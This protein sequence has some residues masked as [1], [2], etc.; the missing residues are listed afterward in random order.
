MRN[1]HIHNFEYF[2]PN[3]ITLKLLRCISTE[4]KIKEFEKK[5]YFVC[6]KQY[7]VYSRVEMYKVGTVTVNL[8]QQQRKSYN[9]SFG[10][11]NLRTLE[12]NY[13]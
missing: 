11:V 10:S 2:Y 3:K 4:D 13:K 6:Q 12:N 5:F 7:Y 1:V 8:V 9:V